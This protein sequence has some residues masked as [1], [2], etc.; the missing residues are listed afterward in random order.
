M[1]ANADIGFGIVVQSTPWDDSD[2]ATWWLVETGFDPEPTPFDKDGKWKD[3]LGRDPDNAAR[4]VRKRDYDAFV[5][6]REVHLAKHVLP[7]TVAGEQDGETRCCV[8]AAGAVQ[9]INWDA[10]EEV[11]PLVLVWHKRIA[12]LDFIEHYFL[13]PDAPKWLVVASLSM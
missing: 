4:S 8:F 6:R 12:Y 13:E 1:D 10:A 2:L 5:T 9:S 3:G 7:I 11:Q